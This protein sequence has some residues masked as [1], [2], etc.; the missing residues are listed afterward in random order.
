MLY[1]SYP[2]INPQVCQTELTTS[3]QQNTHAKALFS[4]T[5]AAQF[6]LDPCL[7]RKTSRFP[8]DNLWITS[9]KGLRANLQKVFPNPFYYTDIMAVYLGRVCQQ[10]FVALRQD[11][12]VVRLYFRVLCFPERLVLHAVQIL[13][14]VAEL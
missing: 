3:I 11:F 9:Q 5:L 6:V 2:Q 13:L 4:A 8:I 7:L 10:L 12:L 1:A 14:A